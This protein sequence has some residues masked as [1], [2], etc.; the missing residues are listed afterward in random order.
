MFVGIN[1]GINQLRSSVSFSPASLFAANEPGVWF[2]PS[3]LATLYQDPAGTTPVTTPGQ[4]VGLMLDKSQGLALGAELWTNTGVIGMSA[5][6]AANGTGW[7]VTS[8]GTSFVGIRLNTASLGTSSYKATVSWSG[9]VNGRSIGILI[10][11]GSTILGTAV[12][13]SVTLVH[14]STGVSASIQLYAVSASIGETF[15]F[16]VASVRELPGNHATQATPTARPN[17]G[18][19]P[20][21][22]R[23]NLLTWSEGFD[24]AFWGGPGATV[25]ANVT[26]APNGTTTADKLAEQATSGGHLI[27][28]VSGLTSVAGQYTNSIYLK[29]AERGFGFVQIATDNAT[30]RYT[31]VVDLSTG[32]VTATSSTGTPTGIAN[33]VVSAGD[34]WWRVSVRAD[35]TSSLAYILAGPVPIGVPTFDANATPTYTGTAG[36]GILLW[37]AQLE[38]GSTATAYQRVTTQYDV[39]EA[40]VASTSYLAFDG[41]DDGMVTGTITPGVDKAQIFAGVRKLSD[42]AL[43]MLVEFSVNAPGASGSFY[44]AA[45]DLPARYSFFSRGNATV[46]LGQIATLSTGTAPDS[47]VITATNN[48]PADLNTLSRNGVP[49]TSATA[50]QGTGNFLAYPLYIGRRGGTTLPFS[51]RVYSLI[52]RFGANLDTPTITNTE[53]WVA[54]KT[55]IAI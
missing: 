18:I 7:N 31:V 4:T 37:G 30:K 14:P 44:L 24:N 28:N 1:L 27:Y 26:T 2:D 36:S 46:V 53:T 17:Y 8:T 16:T 15:T 50:D 49:G 41:V 34:G 21:G 47:A 11:G 54:G 3:D 38:L 48:I 35:H 13:G 52:T 22:G 5:T 9:N 51:G 55:G 32:A 12:S 39:T 42:A 23:R 40:G 20:V 10:G 43:G 6:I 33:S 29:A 19:E 25:S 45:P